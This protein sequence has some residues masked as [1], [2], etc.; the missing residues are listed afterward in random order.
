MSNQEM[1]HL[2]LSKFQQALERAIAH[3][4]DKLYAIHGVGSG[5][6]RNEI[7]A[8]LKQYREVKSFNNDYHPRYGFGA[9]EVILQ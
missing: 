1:L 3:G 7:H 8:L 6:L 9:T 4:A 5:K 2:Q